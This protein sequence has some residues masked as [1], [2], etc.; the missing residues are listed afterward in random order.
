MSAGGARLPVALLGGGGIGRMHAQRMLVHADVR[1]AGVADPSPAARAWAE[2]L[3]VPWAA[4]P[5]DLL[6]RVRPGAAI[7]ATPNATHTAVGLACVERHIPVLVEKPIADTVAEARRLADAARAAGVPV[8][9]GHQRRHGVAVQ[10]ARRMIAE[11]AVG[12]VVAATVLATW[13]KPASYFVAGQWRRLKGGG[14][15]LINAIHDIDLLRHLVGEVASVHAVTSHAERGFEVEDTAAAVLRLAGG[16]LATLLVSDA[17]VSP[18]NYDLASGESELYAPQR[19]DA[20]YLA[21]T[22]G[23]LTVPQLLHWRYRAE[24]REQRHWHAELT[25]E[26]TTLHQHDPYAEQLRHLRAVV[27][28]R[29]APLCSAEEGIATLRA[30]QAVL[31]SAESGRTVLIEGAGAAGSSGGPAGERPAA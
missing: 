16:A 28:G 20:I 17:A 7:V 27:E 9:V 26:Q 15:V 11:G 10:R 2:G 5:A 23:A 30:T 1:L 13:L 19:A 29:E 3:G 25:C 22:E 14:P 18:W 8:L 21:G 12:R 6:D 24:A 31:E 4:E